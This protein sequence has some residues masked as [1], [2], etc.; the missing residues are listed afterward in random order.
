MK[1]KG[2]L[3]EASDLVRDKQGARISFEIKEELTIDFGK[4]VKAISPFSGE[5]I[6]TKIREGIQVQ[7]KNVHAKFEFVCTK[8][9]QK[10]EKDVKSQESKR[11]YY[12]EKQLEINDIFDIFY[13]DI[14][15]MSIDISE[16]IRQE[17]ILHFPP[18]PVCSN[19]CKGLCPTCGADLNDTSC[20]CVTQ[21]SQ[22]EKPL[23][24][25]KT[26]YNAKASST[27]EKNRKIDN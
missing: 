2:L 4:Y 3:F 8:C 9:S 15:N 21:E 24:I 7:M 12:F 1:Q 17:I 14:K 11:I 10:F 18:I 19:S 23:A 27:E 5:I 13:V 16:A 25:L 26:L 6:F 20:K 22:Q